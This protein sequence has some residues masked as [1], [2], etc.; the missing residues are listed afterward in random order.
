MFHKKVSRKATYD[1]KR[2]L[3]IAFF[4]MG[5]KKI[6]RREGV[7]VCVWFGVK[8]TGK[9]KIKI[10]LDDTKIKSKEDRPLS[11]VSPCNRNEKTYRKRYYL[12]TNSKLQKNTL[13]LE[14]GNQSLPK[15]IIIILTWKTSS[16][17]YWN[18]IFFSF[19]K[20]NK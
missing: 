19:L 15:K 11:D 10:K 1:I 13:Q 6:I 9:K 2:F 7:C 12:N 3:D 20:T 5:K 18:N 16:K 17:S 14:E 4:F 8:E